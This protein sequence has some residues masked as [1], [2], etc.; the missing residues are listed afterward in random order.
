ML[1]S[2]L[3]REALDRR[4]AMT[5]EELASLDEAI[6]DH[7]H[8][9]GI[10]AHSQTPLIYV[11]QRG[12]ADTRRLIRERLER[13]LVV[14]VPQVITKSLMRAVATENF[15]RDLAPGAYG[16]LEPVEGHGRTVALE[17][18]DVVLTPGL[19]FDRAGH[20]LG[21]GAG[22]F[23]RFLAQIPNNVARVGLAYGWQLVD[24]LPCDPWDI[25]LTRIVTENGVFQA[26]EAS[27]GG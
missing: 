24:A 13:G 1:K 10:V 20:R 2:D 7:L 17:D 26:T 22:Y 14:C 8:A 11:S 4:R 16:I 19:L 18:I 3:R 6:F 12:E 21:Y 25:A 15:D 9:S 27:E 5:D 23:D